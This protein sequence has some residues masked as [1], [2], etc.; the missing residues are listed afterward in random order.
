MVAL[1]AAQPPVWELIPT[2]PGTVQHCPCHHSPCILGLHASSSPELFLS[3]IATNRHAGTKQ[4]QLERAASHACM[5]RNEHWERV[6]LVGWKHKQVEKEAVKVW[7][8]K[9]SESKNR[10]AGW[11][12]RGIHYHLS[13]APVTAVLASRAGA[14]Q[15]HSVRQRWACLQMP[16]H[17]NGDIRRRFRRKVKPHSS[18]RLSR[19]KGFSIFVLGAS[20]LSTT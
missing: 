1:Q 7:L 11:G 15:R 10:E 8:G 3:F 19:S 12:R 9:R 5:A 16:A 18:A 14:R 17:S 4:L 2:Q 13:T 6:L 20:S